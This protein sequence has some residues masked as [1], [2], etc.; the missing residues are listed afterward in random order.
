[1]PYVDLKRTYAEFVEFTFPDERTAAFAERLFPIDFVRTGDNVIEYKTT[2]P[3][4]IE[5]ARMAMRS[6]GIQWREAESTLTMDEIW[7]SFAGDAYSEDC[8]LPTP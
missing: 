6:M 7:P 3:S 4:V 1:M 8:L 5:R 2:H